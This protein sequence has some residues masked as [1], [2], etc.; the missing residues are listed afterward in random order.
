MSGG[1]T[2]TVQTQ[3]APPQQFLD[4]YSQVLNQASGV[5]QDNPTYQPYQGQQVAGLT[6]PQTEGINQIEGS[7]G[8]ANPYIASAQ[9]YIQN[10]T[11]P[12]WAGVQQFSPGAVSQY[13]SPYTQQ[14]VQATENQ[15]NNQNAQQQTQLAGSAISNGAFGGDRAS[16]AAGVLGGQQQLAEAPTIAGLENQGYSQALGE[17]NTQQQSQLGANEANSWLNSQAGYGMANLGNELEN[18]SLTGANALLNAGGLEQ[19][20]NQENL[21]VP[22]ENYVAAQSYPFQTTGWLANIAEGLGGSSGGTSS[23]SYPGAST[24]SQILGTGLAGAGLLGET[25]AFGAGGYLSGAIS[26]LFGSGAA[27][28]GITSDLGEL[29]AL[30]GGAA[31]GI[32]DFLGAL[33]PSAAFLG[34][35]GGTIPHTEGGLADADRPIRWHGPVERRDD[36]GGLGVLD[37]DEEGDA[38]GLGTYAT[39]SATASMPPPLA[40]SIGGS[41]GDQGGLAALAHGAPAS[42]ARGGDP[43]NALLYTGLGIMGGSSPNAVQNIGKG[44]LQ[45]LNLYETNQERRQQTE[46]LSDYR[47][48]EAQVAQARVKE[49]GRRTDIDAQ[50][51]AAKLA[52]AAQNHLDQLKIEDQRLG[53]ESGGLG[54]RTRHDQAVEDQGHYTWAPGQGPAADGTQT[55]GSWRYSTKSNEAP[56]FFPGVTQQR[57]TDSANRQQNAGTRIQDT[58]DYRSQSLALRNR[59]LDDATTSNIM[60]NASRM[61]AGDPTGHTTLKDAVAAQLSGRQSAAPS[62]AQPSTTQQAPARPVIPQMPSALPPGSQY[63][64]SRQQWRDPAGKLYNGQGQPVQ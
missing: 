57:S 24:G 56:Q 62:T 36:G 12:L 41:G 64:P 16:V 59:G 8:L 9:N 25:G 60:N 18:T 2:N 15:F 53:I 30:G 21:N 46:A 14:V 29:G 61:V 39:S 11:A 51:A 10:S 40:P 3:S 45:G 55:T 38:G 17:F 50:T 6:Q 37:D 23:T 48:N 28:G 20:V 33:G 19:Q 63:S 5:Q 47:Q 7:Q 34:S 52:Q 13:E 4:A 54:E 58:E 43:W 44:A 32:G 35:R 49:A 27:A 26:S 31:G 42:H 1:G 22:Y